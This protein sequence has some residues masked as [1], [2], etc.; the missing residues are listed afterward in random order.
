MNLAFSPGLVLA[1]FLSILIT[2]Q[3]AGDG[4][5]NWLKGVQLL[6]VYLILGIVCFFSS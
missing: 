6:A 5:S 4:E 3:I 2:G 1:V